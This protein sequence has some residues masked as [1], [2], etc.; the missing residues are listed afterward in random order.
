M[1]GSFSIMKQI[2][3]LLLL[4]TLIIS[5]LLTGCGKETKPVEGIENY[6][7]VD[8]LFV[9]VSADKKS[10]PAFQKTHGKFV[11]DFVRLFRCDL[12]RLEG[13]TDL[14]RDYVAPLFTSGDLAILPF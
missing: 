13:L 12:S 10:V 3:K 8:M 5:V 1:G 9:N 6:V 14:V 4:F 2:R 7:G 11:A